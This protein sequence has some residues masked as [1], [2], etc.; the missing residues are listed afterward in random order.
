MGKLRWWPAALIVGLGLSWLGWL[1][2]VSDV[3]RQQ[4][5]V[6]PSPPRAGS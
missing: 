5:V 6:G 3:I 2:L 1:W 4:K